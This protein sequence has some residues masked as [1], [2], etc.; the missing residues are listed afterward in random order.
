MTSP[1]VTATAL[2][3]P[4]TSIT[5]NAT[6]VPQNGNLFVGW[7][8]QTNLV[9][10]SNVTLKNGVRTA[11]IP[12]GMTGIAFAALTNQITAMTVDGLSNATLAGPAPVL[13]S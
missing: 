8:N 6:G 9:V 4:P 5:F 12:Q 7:V 10:Y 11:D 1:V 2:A 13:M 3:T